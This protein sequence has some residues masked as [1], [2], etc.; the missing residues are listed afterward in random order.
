[1]LIIYI[2][3]DVSMVKLP[4]VQTGTRGQH[5][6]IREDSIAAPQKVRY[7]Y[8]GKNQKLAPQVPQTPHF[9]ILINDIMHVD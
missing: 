6:E 5:G 9:V 8:M 3:D 4:T 2:C 7:Q 1:M